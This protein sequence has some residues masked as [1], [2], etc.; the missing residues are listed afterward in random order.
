MLHHWL[1]AC[2]V[3]VTGGR[4]AICGA[5]LPKLKWGTG[6]G[7]QGLFGGPRRADLELGAGPLIMGA[8]ALCQGLPSVG[9]S[10]RQIFNLAS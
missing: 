4:A 3:A 1:T 8:M 5:T 6:L 9:Y 7:S 10:N 2:R